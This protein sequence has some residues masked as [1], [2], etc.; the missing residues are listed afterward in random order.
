MFTLDLLDLSIHLI[1]DPAFLAFTNSKKRE[2]S[3]SDW[4]FGDRLNFDMFSTLWQQHLPMKHQNKLSKG[5]RRRREEGERGGERD[6]IRKKH[7]HVH[8]IL[9]PHHTYTVSLPSLP[10]YTR[11]LCN[12]PCRCYTKVDATQLP[13]MESL[14][15]QHKPGLSPTTCIDPL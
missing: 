5:R 3:M 11:L 1:L 4:V 15:C 6:V 12:V 7:L 9:C 14:L 13:T 10:S 8:W 2:G